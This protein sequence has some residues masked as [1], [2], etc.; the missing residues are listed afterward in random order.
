M[1]V[2]KIIKDEKKK[3]EIDSAAYNNTIS[4]QKRKLESNV[5][6]SDVMLSSFS[7]YL[8]NE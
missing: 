8:A 5:F 1:D 6:T 7:L 4:M 2:D 3:Q